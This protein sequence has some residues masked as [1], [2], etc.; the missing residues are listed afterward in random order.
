MDKLTKD[1]RVPNGV[2]LVFILAGSV[3]IF[4]GAYQNAI[5]FYAIGGFIFLFGGYMLYMSFKK[6][7]DFKFVDENYKTNPQECMIIINESIESIKHAIAIDQK[8]EDRG[9]K[10]SKDSADDVIRKT[11]RLEKFI[12]I[13]AEIEKY[14]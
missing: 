11:A 3:G 6:N 7:K 4:L 14:S 2:S 8:K 13:K 10:D 12:S 9:G 5:L 1:I